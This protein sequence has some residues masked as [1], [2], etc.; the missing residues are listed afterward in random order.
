MTFD[1]KVNAETNLKIS[2]WLVLLL[3]VH[4]CEIDN[5]C[6]VGE[7]KR[8]ALLVITWKIKVKQGHTMRYLIYMRVFAMCP[9]I[10]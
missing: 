6:F 10:D 2:I 4:I 7:N 3:V 9:I 1:S 5:S 8:F